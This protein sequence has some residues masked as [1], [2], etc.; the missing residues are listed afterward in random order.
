LK[1]F[2]REQIQ[3]GRMVPSDIFGIYVA[4]K[5]KITNKE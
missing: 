3:N 2:V 1:A 4:N 5:T